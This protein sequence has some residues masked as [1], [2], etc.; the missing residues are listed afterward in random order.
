M[1]YILPKQDNTIAV[2][3][4]LLFIIKVRFDKPLYMVRIKPNR[5]C[6]VAESS[7]AAYETKKHHIILGAWE[8]ES[9]IGLHISSA[10]GLK[11]DCLKIV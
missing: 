3:A 6:H 7:L 4:L 5:H 9:P 11:S 8:A 1:K 2:D 10:K